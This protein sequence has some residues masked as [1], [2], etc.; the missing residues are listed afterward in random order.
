MLRIGIVAGEAS[1]DRLGADLIRALRSRRPELSIEGIGG[2]GMT[3]AGC[4]SLASM[5]RLS[6]MGLMEVIGRYRELS[7]LRENIAAHFLRHPPDLFIGIDAPDFNLGLESR[8]RAKGIKTVHY[9]SPQVWAWREYRLRNIRQSVDLML[10]LLPFEEQYYQRHGIPVRFVGHPAADRIALRPDRSAA[11]T[12]LGLPAEGKLVALMPGSRAT[13]LDRLIDP[14][15]QAAAW[16]NSNRDGLLFATSM[17]GD[18]S[19]Q[20]MRQAL[21]TPAFKD[22]PVQVYKNRADDVLEAADTALLAS[23]TVT[24]EAMLYKLPMVVAYKMNPITF[25]LIK[26]MVKINFA[27]LPNL[28]A[29]AEI[30]PEYL[31]GACRPQRLGKRLL[32]WLDDP[33]AVSRLESTYSSIH[34]KLRHDASTTAARSMLELLESR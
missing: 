3:G 10:V 19:V 13:E 20:R 17:L 34:T 1:G 28:L 2:P 26:N 9:V 29:G 30:V 24:L 14:F 22:L 6:V 31:Q 5:D 32:D 23:G 21:S 25:Y 27:S 11:R 18:E 16:C 7:R 33:G 8:L 15:L 12:R 4:R